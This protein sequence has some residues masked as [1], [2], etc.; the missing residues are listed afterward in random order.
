LSINAIRTEKAKQEWRRRILE[1]SSQRLGKYREK[2]IGKTSLLLSWRS[3]LPPSDQVRDAA[4]A[5]FRVW[6]S[7]RDPDA[8]HSEQAAKLA[9][10]IYDGLDSLNLLPASEMPDG[11]RILEAAALAHA[12]GS[13]GT[14]KK[15]QIVAYRMIRKIKPPIGLSSEILRQIAL[16]VRFHRGA[17][18]RSEQKALTGITD[19]QRTILMLLSGILRLADAFDRLHGSRINQLR[20]EKTGDVILVTAP[21]Y[22]ENDAAAEKLAAARHLLEIACRLPIFIRGTSEDAPIFPA[23]R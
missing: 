16:V 23:S 20:L 11:R 5:R 1:E 12:V 22:S 14:D 3:E 19:R 17:L 10:Q 8:F 15:H 13:N 6:A 18:P 9:M 2:M 7:F 4:L 21:G